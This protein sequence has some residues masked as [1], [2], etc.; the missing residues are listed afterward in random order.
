ML[1]ITERFDL[2]DTE[3]LEI[4]REIALS[5]AD[6]PK[7]LSANI[8]KEVEEAAIKIDVCPKCFT[9]LEIKRNEGPFCPDCGW[10][11]D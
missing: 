10:E 3:D 2:R 4:L 8:L 1:E 11:E 6:K 5:I 7:E 9:T